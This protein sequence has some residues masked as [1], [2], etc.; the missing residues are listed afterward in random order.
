MISAMTRPTR[1]RYTPIMR[2]LI[3]ALALIPT[4]VLAEVA[5]P[6]EEIDGDTAIRCCPPVWPS[7]I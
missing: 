4:S 5:G 7:Y 1:H 3:A 2:Y 6:A